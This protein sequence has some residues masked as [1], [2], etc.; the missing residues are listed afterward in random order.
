[1][2]SNFIDDIEKV[3]EMLNL[4]KEEFLKA[5][6]NLTDKEYE[7]TKKQILKFVETRKKLYENLNSKNK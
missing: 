7:N 3:K 5:Y 1:M 2:E 6:N 4:S